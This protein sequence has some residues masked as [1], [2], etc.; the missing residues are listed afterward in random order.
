MKPDASMTRPVLNQT[1]DIV[2]HAVSAGVLARRLGECRKSALIWAA[3]IGANADVLSNISNLFLPKH[4]LY[5]FF[6][7]LLFQGIICLLVLFLNRR[8]AFGGLLHIAIDVVSHNYTTLFLFYPFWQFQSHAG[9]NWYR[10]EGILVWAMLWIILA[11]IIYREYY[12]LRPRPGV[13]ASAEFAE[14]EN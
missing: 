10:F 11:L 7:S 9:I 6:H 4:A 13:C 5:P 1:M 12:I 14:G 3:L 2:F 8:I